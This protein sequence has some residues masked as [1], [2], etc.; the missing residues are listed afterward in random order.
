MTQATN[1]KTFKQLVGELATVKTAEDLR[2]LCANID[3]SYQH[4]KITFKDNETLYGII[5]KFVVYTLTE[6]DI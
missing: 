4:D 6:T 3:L 5:N 1:Y 2:N